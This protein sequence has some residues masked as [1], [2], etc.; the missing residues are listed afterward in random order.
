L[1]KLRIVP[2]SPVEDPATFLLHDLD[3]LAFLGGIPRAIPGC[4][5]SMARGDE[6]PDA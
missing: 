1:E 3:M 6:K 4:H 2:G 5:E